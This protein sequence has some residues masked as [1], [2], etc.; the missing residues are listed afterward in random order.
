MF[1]TLLY[2][3]EAWTLNNKDMKRLEAF[4]MWAYRRILKV[5]WTEKVRNTEILVRVQ[6]NTEIIATVKKR[7]LEYFGH[8][9]R[10]KKYRLLQNIMQGK[11]AGR[12]APGRRKTSWMK[13]LRDWFDMSSS[14]LFRL[15]FDKIRIAKM[16]TNVLK[17]HGT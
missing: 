15:A 6:K 17:G 13:N 4:E 9:M 16:V 3:V 10:G 11:I 7:K 1:S 2:G 8:V 14:K 5:A 12:R